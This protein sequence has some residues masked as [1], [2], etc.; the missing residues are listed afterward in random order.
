MSAITPKAD[1]CG[2]KGNVR[3]VPIA[4]IRATALF[5]DLRQRARPIDKAQLTLC[6]SV[7]KTS[8]H[9]FIVLVT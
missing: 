9:K 1:M 8:A 3:F 6:K 7:A 4:D 5:L 2:A